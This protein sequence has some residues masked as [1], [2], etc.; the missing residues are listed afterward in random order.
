MVAIN[1]KLRPGA[2]P[3]NLPA[4]NYYLLQDTLYRVAALTD[5]GGNIVEAYDTDAYGN[6]L[7]FTAA[8]PSGNWQVVQRYVYISY[9]TITV[10][11]ADWSTPPTGTQPL[12]D[13]LYQGMTLDQVTGLYDERFRNYSP[14]L[15]RW[16]NQ[17]P[18]GYINGANTYQFVVSDPA[19]NVDP[20]GVD[21]WLETTWWGHMWICVGNANYF[22]SFSFGLNSWWDLF[23]PLSQGVVYQDRSVPF[24]SP[25]DTAGYL[26]TTPAQD[27]VATEILSSELNEKMPYRLTYPNCRTFCE[28]NFRALQRR[29]APPAQPTQAGGREGCRP[30]RPGRCLPVFLLRGGA[31]FP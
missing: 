21:V 30:N 16:I 12:V 20:W 19:E 1:E 8:D 11:N 26:Y 24:P 17:D 29:F 5:S 31:A 22:T 4:G 27:T 6:T 18:A 10:L 25:A 9:G 23:N 3:Q 14:S 7:I 13:N 28:A 2:G 15:G